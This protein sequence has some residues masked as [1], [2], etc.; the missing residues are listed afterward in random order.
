MRAV[1]VVESLFGNTRAVAD[2]IAA[3]IG[4]AEVLDVRDAPA[5]LDED[6][7][8]LVLGGPTHAFGMSRTNTRADAV[9]QGGSDPGIGLRDFLGLLEVHQDLRVAVFDTRVEKVRHLPGSAARGA[10]K[11]LRHL[12]YPLA[13]QPETFYVSGT[14]GPLVEGERERARSWGRQLAELMVSPTHS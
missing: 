6:A 4:D 8:L 13:A 10:A 1:I 9:R 7:N 11:A 5:A 12:D 3:G 14:A 2:E